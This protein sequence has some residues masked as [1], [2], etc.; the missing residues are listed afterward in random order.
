MKLSGYPGRWTTAKA[1]LAVAGALVIAGAV[2]SAIAMS[3]T[4]SPSDQMAGRLGPAL[5]IRALRGL[6]RVGET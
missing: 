4:V 3:P 2:G 1:A 5:R 6:C